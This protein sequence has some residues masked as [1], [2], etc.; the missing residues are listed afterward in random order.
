MIDRSGR[1]ALLR[2]FETRCDRFCKLENAFSH[3]RLGNSVISADEFKCFTFGQGIVFDARDS[4]RG[5]SWLSAHIETRHVFEKKRNWNVENLTDLVQP[6]GANAIHAPL[7]FLDLLKRQS[8]CFAEFFLTHTEKRPAKS[9]TP[10]Y[11]DVNWI[12]YRGH[13]DNSPF[14]GFLRASGFA[15]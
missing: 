11:M 4:T 13:V 6:A 5:D 9:D 2:F 10:T 14:R 12:G 15:L 3:R 7:V 1:W 8:K